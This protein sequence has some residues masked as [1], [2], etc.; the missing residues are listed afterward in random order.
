MS[1]Q[2]KLSHIS[3]IIATYKST[4]MIY[5]LYTCRFDNYAETMVINGKYV[6]LN[7][8]DTAGQEDY[9]RLRPLSYPLTDIFLICY[10]VISPT[11]YDNVV[12]KWYPEISH[13]CPSAPIIL[14]GTKT[15]LREDKEIVQELQ[16]RGKQPLTA[17]QGLAMCKKIG[18]KK[19][20]ECSALTQKGLKQVFTTAAEMG[21]FPENFVSKKKKKA[22]CRIM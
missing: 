5:L 19:Y 2:C 6:S 11:S 10:S 13:H 16:M 21:A 8:W 22:R 7:L 3:I 1:Q 12:E 15:D 17:T 18:A 14:V 20:I 4:G 9:D